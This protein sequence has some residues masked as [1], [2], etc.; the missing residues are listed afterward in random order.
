MIGYIVLT[1]PYYLLN[2]K[3]N[4][5]L[6]K[7]KKIMHMMFF[8]TLIPL[9]YWYIQHAVKRRAGAYSIYAY[10][11]WSLIIQD[12]INDHLYADDYKDVDLGI[13]CWNERFTDIRVFS[14]MRS[15]TFFFLFGSCVSFFFRWRKKHCLY[16][17]QH[18]R[19]S[20]HVWY[21]SFGKII[22]YEYT[23]DNNQK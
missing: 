15:S 16:I 9:I 19:N 5:S 17:P 18:S 1:I 12:I 3:S 21:Q 10:F 14:K 8:V 20:S 4:R 13:S 11:E 6:K 2:Y 23:S 22:V 7:V